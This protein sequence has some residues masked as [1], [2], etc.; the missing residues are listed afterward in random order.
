M[1]FGI[2]QGFLE[3]KNDK[4]IYLPNKSARG[5]YVTLSVKAQLKSFFCDLLFSTKESSLIW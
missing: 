2:S 5:V 3:R 1:W 4:N